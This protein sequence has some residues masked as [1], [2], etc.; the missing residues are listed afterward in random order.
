[1]KKSVTDYP[2]GLLISVLIIFLI[3][4]YGSKEISAFLQLREYQE[5]SAQ[6]MGIVDSMNYL[7]ESN[8]MYSFLNV[9]LSVPKGQ[10]ITFDDENDS[11]ILQGYFNENIP[12]YNDL[13][14]YIEINSGAN[15]YNGS[16]I[17]C[18]YGCNNTNLPYAV[19][20]R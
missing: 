9:E 5:F 1:M 20:F 10:N 14:N 2:I 18:Y 16:I 4:Y 3:V 15:D 8:A 13:T 19:I 7:K 17:I 6:V 11:I 12:T